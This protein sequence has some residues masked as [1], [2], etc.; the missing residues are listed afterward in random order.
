MIPDFTLGLKFVYILKKRLTNS[1]VST[2]VK[3]NG[4]V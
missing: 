4:F 2:E 1:L 3:L